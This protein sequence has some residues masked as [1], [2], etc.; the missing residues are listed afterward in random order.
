MKTLGYSVARSSSISTFNDLGSVFIL[1][2]METTSIPVHPPI[3]ARRTST[4]RAALSLP[5]TAG[6]LSIITGCPLFP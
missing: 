4:G 3:E 5:P 6:E 1:R 2:R